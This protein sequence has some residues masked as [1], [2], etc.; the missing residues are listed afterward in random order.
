[1]HDQD[2][3]SAPQWRLA[4]PDVDDCGRFERRT[5][6]AAIEIAPVAGSNHCRVGNTPGGPVDNR[7]ASPSIG[8]A[9]TER[10]VV[11]GRDGSD[12]PKRLV[13]CVAFPVND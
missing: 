8:D 1:M 2:K 6:V 13:V 9:A 10:L 12:L 7:G 11:S 5:A 3:S 4:R